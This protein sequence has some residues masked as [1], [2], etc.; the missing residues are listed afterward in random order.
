VIADLLPSL[1][2]ATQEAA[3]ACQPWVGRGDGK[4]A[5]AAAVAALRDMLAHCQ[6]QGTVVIGEGEKD[7]A[8]MLFAGERV[9]AGGLP[10]FDV[11][12]DPLENTTACASAG[13]GAVAV[14]A[15]APARTLWTTPAWY[16]D[17]L[18][19]PAEA[20]GAADITWPLERKLAAVA[21]A[22]GKRVEELVAVVLDKPRHVELVAR[23]RANGVSVALIGDGDVLGALR[24]V[25][26]DGDAD[27]LLGVGGA[28]EGVISACTVRV[29]GG[30]M[31]IR[32]APQSRD[33]AARLQAAGQAQGSVMGLDELVAS[34]D[35]AVA[36]TGITGCALLGAPRRHGAGWT[37]ESIGM[38][39]GRA[40]QR[41]AATH[42][43]RL[44]ERSPACLT[45][46]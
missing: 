6:G 45:S 29:L 2:A 32:H 5:D 14:V 43:R 39:S 35:C 34:D 17:K 22:V 8:P 21:E 41:V 30:G 24:V 46:W 19:V 27:I 20:A 12:V 18:V 13:E 3:L 1:L 38:A 42:M 23:L 16:V 25:M 10:A 4:A 44:P 28:P 26:P 33:E 31:Q 11:A 15:A 7:A 36:I 9:G 40:V 37:T